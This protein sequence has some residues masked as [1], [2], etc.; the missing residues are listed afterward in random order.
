MLC[1]ALGAVA[2]PASAQGTAT[3]R[4]FRGLFGSAHGPVATHSLDVS[5]S[6]V[7]AYDDD[8]MAETGSVFAPTSQQV[9]GTFTMFSPSVRYSRSGRKAQIGLNASAALA[10]Y[11]QIGGVRSLSHTAGVGF[12]TEFGR[13]RVM[14]NQSLAYSP[15]YLYGLFP[16]VDAVGPGT[17]VAAG[18][19]FDVDQSR[20]YYYGTV[21][22][23]SR[24]F[25]RRGSISASAQYSGTDFQGAAALRR[26]DVKAFGVG[27]SFSRNLSRNTGFRIGYSYRGGDVGGDGIAAQTTAHGIDIGADFS[28]PLSATRRAT[29]GVTLGSSA[30]GATEGDV[31]TPGQDRRYRAHGSTSFGYQFSSRWQARATYQRDLQYVPD[32]AEPVF[33]DGVTVSLDG[34]L[35]PRMDF[36]VSGHYTNANSALTRDAATLDTY[37]LDG[38]L[39]YAVSRTWA[40]YGEYLYYFYEFTKRTP[41]SAEV[42]PGLERSGVR[43]G[44][45]LWLP[46]YR[47]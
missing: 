39:R 3:D 4:P 7:E 21:L 12:A 37:A 22:N 11:P 29:F 24:P 8:V 34:L 19:D 33:T 38:R 20:S 28:K 45:T 47:R 36:L 26:Q 6:L 18:P 16:T 14:L 25:T 32:F 27:T 31:L 17:A 42:P 40:I 44:L 15:A 35:S 43:V 46:I 2:A 41:G 23:V 5:A 1:L 10:H 9:G 13:T 30:I